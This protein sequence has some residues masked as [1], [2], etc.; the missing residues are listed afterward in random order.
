[1]CRADESY[2]EGATII[3]GDLVID[4]KYKVD[5]D[6]IY[7]ASGGIT[8]TGEGYRPTNINEI[9]TIYKRSITELSKLLS[10]DIPNSNI[11]FTRFKYIYVGVFGA[12][13]AFLCDTCLCYVNRK[14]EYTKAYL[15]ANECFKDKKINISDIFENYDK[16]KEVVNEQIENMLYYKLPIVKDIFRKTFNISFPNIGNVYE[17]VQTRHDIVHRN[18]R[19]IK[20][21][22][23]LIDKHKIERLITDV[24]TLVYAI[25]DEFKKIDS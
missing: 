11:S 21:K 5:S 12:M 17:Y 22:I 3:E 20:G 9:L 16:I 19:T 2:A 1:M 13:E 10:F 24:N 4:D 7:I 14:S 25:A 8:V 23:I 6:T 18:G 15:K